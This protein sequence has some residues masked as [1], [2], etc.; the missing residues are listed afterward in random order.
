[1]KGA[2]ALGVVV[3]FTLIA[4]AP[5]EQQY[6]QQP[7]QQSMNEVSTMKLISANFRHDGKI[8]AKHTCDG[9]D[10]SPQLSISDLPEGTESLVLIMDDPD[11]VKPAGRVWDHWVVWNIPATTTEIPEGKEPEGIHGL[12]SSGRL[13]YSGPCPPDK[14]HAYHFK[15][16]ALDIPDIG[17]PE[18]ATKADVEAAMRG[19]VIGQVELVGRYQRS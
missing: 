1:M 9:N 12:G 11:A 19:H 10:V 15:L 16:Y 4:C 6:I 18:G 2:L 5:Q 7:T 8:P 14:E 3:L 13:G 17:L